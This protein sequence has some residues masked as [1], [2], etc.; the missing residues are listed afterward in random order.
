MVM[1]G[2]RTGGDERMRP[3]SEEGGHAAAGDPI[4]VTRGTGGREYNAAANGHY[5]VGGGIARIQA[6]PWQWSSWVDDAAAAAE[7]VAGEI[8]PHRGS[9]G[10]K[11]VTK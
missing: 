6:W 9:R 11:F 7:V 2:E 5:G 3:T 10:R 8:G 4:K 1:D